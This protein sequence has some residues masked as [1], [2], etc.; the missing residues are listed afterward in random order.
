MDMSLPLGVSIV[1]GML[2]WLVSCRCTVFVV[3][4]LSLGTF[5]VTNL[6]CSRVLSAHSLGCLPQLWI[7]LPRVV[8]VI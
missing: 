6:S 3:S 5:D 1:S 7:F 2:C 4:S 8:L